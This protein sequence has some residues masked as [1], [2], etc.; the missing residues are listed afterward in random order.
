MCSDEF[1]Y[2]LIS[3]VRTR[4]CTDRKIYEQPVKH[5]SLFSTAALKKTL[6]HLHLTPLQLV[7][8]VKATQVFC[9][10]LNSPVPVV[11]DAST[12]ETEV[13]SKPGREYRCLA[14]PL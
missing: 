8:L 3:C 7:R 12:T 6:L 9:H 1:K 4:K 2:L 5:Q 14:F 11:G 13:G 10:W